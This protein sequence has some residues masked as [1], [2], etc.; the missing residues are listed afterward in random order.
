M[1]PHP[2]AGPPRPAARRLRIGASSFD[3]AERVVLVGILNVT[4]DSFSDGGLYLDPD[5]AARRALEMADEGADV[6]DV[7]GEST[8]PGSLPVAAGEE[9]GRVVPVIEAVRRRSDIPI[10]IDTT[11]AEVARAAVE[12]GADM[13]NDISGLTRDPEML[14]VLRHNKLPVI[15]MHSKGEPAAMQDDPRYDDLIGEISDFLRAGAEAALAA[16]APPGGV[17]VDPG[18]GFGKTAEH[19]LTILKRLPELAALGYPLLV[20]PS[21]KSFIGAALGLEVDQR[22]E[23]TLA[24]AAI[25]VANGASLVRLH[26]VKQGRRAVDLAAKIRGASD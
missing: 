20:G 21:R 25:A 7:G 4:P 24:A 1:P 12:A 18:I 19:N 10:S 22:L 13:L 17:V 6:V 3:L 15:I 8:R 26:D 16:G 9:L 5:R 2:E 11:K 23:S 14:N